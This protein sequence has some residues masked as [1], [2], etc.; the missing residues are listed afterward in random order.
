MI[1]TL[2]GALIA[3]KKPLK[4]KLYTGKRIEYLKPT[5]LR[6]Q[7]CL[8]NISDETE[9]YLI[10]NNSKQTL[11]MLGDSH[12]RSL[13]LAGKEVA[14]T[15]G[16]NMKLYTAGA[17]SFPPVGYYQKLIKGGSLRLGDFKI[18]EK[19]LYKQIKVGDIILLSMRMPYHFGGTYYE[20]P[21]S[22]F[23][24]I[25]KDGSFGSQENYFDNWIASVV[26]L[27][28]IAQKKGTKIIIQTPTPE[29]EEEQLNNSCTKNEWFNISLKRNCQIESKFFI[30]EKKGVYKHLF[31][32]LNRLSSSHPNIYIFDTYKIVC[33]ESTCSFIKNDVEIYR[34][35]DHLS[36]GWAR[37]ILAPE[38]SSFINEIQ[39][40][41]K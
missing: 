11:W 24:F 32:K 19:E 20:Y 14:N 33:P 4:G 31:K 29:W 15:L 35:D 37:D 9:C 40:M 25:K 23:V 21:T 12:T 18:V 13:A 41:N 3:L 10:E 17:T 7:K 36:Y 2:S 5:F 28:N 6:G 30:D 27:A 39:N 26:N 1:V 34:D 38:I 22:S 8:E 16:M